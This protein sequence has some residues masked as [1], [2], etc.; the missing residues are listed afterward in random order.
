MPRN[1]FIVLLVAGACFGVVWAV[2]PILD[3]PQGLMPY[4][5]TDAQL[6]RDRYPIHLISTTWVSDHDFRDVVHWTFAEAL[7]RL[8]ATMIAIFIIARFARHEKPAA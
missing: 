8:L 6:I 4:D 3:T 1:I 2:H 7:A 5:W